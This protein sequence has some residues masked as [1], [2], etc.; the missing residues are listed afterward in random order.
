V[1]RPA[2]R[3][4]RTGGPWFGNQLMTL[5]LRGRGARVRLDQARRGRDGRTLLAPVLDF[6]IGTEVGTEI[7]TEVGTKTG[8]EVGTVASNE[9]GTPGGHDRS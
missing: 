2:I 3:W 7:G 9:I 8:I 1:G 4:R 5:T 6:E